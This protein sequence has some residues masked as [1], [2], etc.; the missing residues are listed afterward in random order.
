MAAEVDDQSGDLSTLYIRLHGAPEIY[1][2]AYDD[3]FIAGIAARMQRARERNGTA[4][5]I[6]DNTARGAAIPNAL[7]LMAQLAS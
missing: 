7:T 5:C 4:W 1:Y 2:S 6:F 3:E